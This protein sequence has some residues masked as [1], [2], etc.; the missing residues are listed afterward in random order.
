MPKKFF[1]TTPIYYMNGYPH[2][3]HYY[4][5]TVADTLARIFRKKQGAFFLTGTDE[6]GEKVAKKAQEGG[7]TP[8]EFTDELA[9]EWCQTWQNMDIAYDYFIRTTDE[10]H[11]QFAQYII[12]TLQERGALYEQEYQALYCVGA[13]SFVSKSDLREGGLCPDHDESPET[14][15]ERNWF[16]KLS[17]YKATIRDL[18]HSD[19]LKIT[20]QS[21]KNEVL[22][23]LDNPQVTD[24]SVTR[25]RVSWGIPVPFDSNQTIYVWI[26]ALFNYLSAVVAEQN[27]AFQGR[28]IEDVLADLDM[29]WPPDVHLLGKDIVKFHAIYWPAFLLALGVPEDSLPRELLVTGMFLSQ[30]RKM[31]K[32]LGNIVLPQ[33]IIDF[34]NQETQTQRGNDILRYYVLR[35]MRLG[36]DGDITQERVEE[37]YQSELVNKVGNTFHRV[38]GMARKYELMDARMPEKKAQKLEESIDKE[39]NK[40]LQRYDIYEALAYLQHLCQEIGHGIETAKPWEMKKQGQISELEMQ[41][42]QWMTLLEILA[43]KFAPYL[44]ESS[45]VMKDLI[46]GGDVCLFPRI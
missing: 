8:K 10:H 1:V 40:R 20:P 42:G 13:E 24:F 28:S 31:S 39:L 36:N 27:I 38:V 16:F 45:Q 4:A 17:D 18:I 41:L 23:M 29:V 33:D 11:K 7:Y 2:L 43:D 15:D 35:E 12:Q 6:H 25:E 5:T 22:E 19:R 44:P 34:F 21:R 9:K 46:K 32:S 3:G 26:D 37:V 30:G 14:I